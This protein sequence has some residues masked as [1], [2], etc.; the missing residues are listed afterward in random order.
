MKKSQLLVCALLTLG[1]AV[2]GCNKANHVVVSTQNA[3]T[4][5]VTLV[6]K[7]PVGRHGIQTMDMK[8]TSEITT[9]WTKQPISQ[10]MTLG[11]E[12]SLTVLREMDGGKRELQLEYLGTTMSMKQGMKTLLTFDS[13]K[14][15][16]GDT[17]PAAAIL[18]KII[19]AKVGFILNAANE[20][21]TVTGAEELAQRITSAPGIDPAGT[22]KN[23]FSADVLKQQVDFA[24]FLPGKPVQ[25]GD[26]W[27]V[28]RDYPMGQMGTMIM[29]FNFT[30]AGWEKHHDRWCAKIDM[31]GT[32]TSKPSDDSDQPAMKITVNDGK[33][34][35][36]TWFDIDEGMFVDGTV[37]QDMKMD[38]TMKNP[39]ASRQPNAP[40]TVTL[41]SDM[42][43]D[44][45]TSFKLK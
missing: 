38:I 5:P 2:T 29:N 8:M 6:L 14:S 39:L 30:L 25:P 13:A 36:E 24:H 17:N 22:M 45:T 40:A 32:V 23:M 42:H 43:Q 16:A 19:G 1:L 28:E 35:G 31:D 11:Q 27:P 18:G 34:S 4:G 7:W 15:G 21:E 9:P 12:S 20:V 10:D 3:P 41:N 37:N 44:I 33:C 26:T